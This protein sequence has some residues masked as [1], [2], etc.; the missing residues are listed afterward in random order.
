MPREGP[1]RCLA[2]SESAPVTAAGLPKVVDLRQ[3]CRAIQSLR[4]PVPPLLQR[5]LSITTVGIQAR[6][7]SE[8]FLARGGLRGAERAGPGAILTVGGEATTSVVGFRI[9]FSLTCDQRKMRV[10]NEPPFLV[11][12]LGT[13]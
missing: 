9:L 13:H 3:S 5:S 10:C 8:V 2:P 6:F 12:E 11:R 4:H 7:Q 1:R